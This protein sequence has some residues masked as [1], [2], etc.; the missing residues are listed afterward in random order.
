M[1]Y[2][3]RPE[4]P[5]AAAV[6]CGTTCGSAAAGL[7]A[8]AVVAAAF[9]MPWAA[10]LM[11]T[12]ADL[13]VFRVA[14]GIGGLDPQAWGPALGAVPALALAYLVLAAL[15]A[16]GIGSTA[17]PVRALESALF[18]V[19]AAAFSLSVLGHVVSQ[20]LCA[21]AVRSYGAPLPGGVPFGEM[22]DLGSAVASVV[23]GST[24]ISVIPC[25]I[26]R[27]DGP[28]SRAANAMRRYPVARWL[29]LSA[30]MLATPIIVTGALASL[31]CAGVL[32]ASLVWA[33]VTA[34][35]V[36]VGVVVGVALALVAV[37]VT[38]FLLVL[39]WPCFTIRY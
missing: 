27:G 21:E 17:K 4:R 31:F 15:R 10:D 7:Q 13:E 2:R 6:P 12:T 1:T 14:L 16:L 36:A 32:V 23:V 11:A 37:V 9:A 24:M 18:W 25:A 28:L 38:F 19:S 22:V 35:V 3:A 39:F 5:E 26:R 34:V 30:S 8:L 20:M 33:A 29:L